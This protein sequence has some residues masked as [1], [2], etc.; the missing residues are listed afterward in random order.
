MH[1]LPSLSDE[2][3]RIESVLELLELLGLLELLLNV[4]TGVDIEGNDHRLFSA[5]RRLFEVD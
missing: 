3:L 4:L 1:R 5:G 2:K